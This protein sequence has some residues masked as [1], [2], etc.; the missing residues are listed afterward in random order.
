M[1]KKFSMPLQIAVALFLA[2]VTGILVPEAATYFSWM[3]TLFIRA[4]KMIV[5]PLVLTSII[6][7]MCKLQGGKDFGRLGAKTLG[8]YIGTSLI[9][10]V[11]GLVL[12]NFFKPGTGASLG[13]EAN[14]EKLPVAST[15]LF[16]N[17]MRIVPENIFRALADTDMLAIIFIAMVF[18]YFTT[19]LN[20]K[21][22]TKLVNFFEAANELVMRVTE[23]II[24]FSPFGIFGIVVKIV[25]EQQNLLELLYR[26][27][28]YMLVV[29]IGLIIHS[30]IILPLI[31]RTTAGVNPLRHAK[32]VL[33]PLLTAFSTS[34]SNAAL[35]LTMSA[36]EKN[37]GV[38]VKISSFT[39]PLG[40]TI[41][42]NGTALYEFVAAMFIA[43][44]YGIQLTIGQQIITIFTALMA[45]IGA[46]GIPMAGMVTMGIVLTAVGLPLEGM[47]LIL[48]VDRILD[49]FRTTVNVWGDTVC[50]A[51][52]AKSEGEKIYSNKA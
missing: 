15:T 6:F 25:S 27:G 13:L 49:M 7:G 44:A 43:Q 19:V 10:I 3:G 46:A 30:A 16:E 51:I 21:Y 38:S 29:I 8:W 22:K 26:L 9:A 17:M 2:V 35:P 23:F 42:M 48:A 39:L 41:N 12:V 5:A 52:I 20:D 31:L 34:S 45:S 50:C 36:M 11:T 4:L 18:G 33:T 37:A 14:L 47:G 32:A 40:A 24:R 28:L 1:R